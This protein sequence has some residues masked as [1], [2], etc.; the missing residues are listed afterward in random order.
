MGEKVGAGP[1]PLEDAVRAL[2]SVI[3]EVEQLSSEKGGPAG[4]LERVLVRERGRVTQLGRKVI[5]LAGIEDLSDAEMQTFGRLALAQFLV[6]RKKFA[7]LRQAL[8]AALEGGLR[9]DAKRA[10]RENIVKFI[11]ALGLHMKE[12]DALLQRRLEMEIAQLE[13][14]RGSIDR[15]SPEAE[16]WDVELDSLKARLEQFLA[17][18]GPC[19]QNE[20]P[21]RGPTGRTQISPQVSLQLGELSKLGCLCNHIRGKRPSRKLVARET[22][23]SIL[24]SGAIEYREVFPRL[25]HLAPSS[26]SAPESRPTMAACLPDECAASESVDKCEEYVVRM[27]S[28][29]GHGHKRKKRRGQAGAMGKEVRKLVRGLWKHRREKGVL[30][31]KKLRALADRISSKGRRPLISSAFEQR[32][33]G[34]F[35]RSMVRLVYVL[36]ADHANWSLYLANERTKGRL[37]EALVLMSKKHAEKARKRLG[38]GA[39]GKADYFAIC[40]QVTG[41]L[42][43]G[44]GPMQKY[45]DKEHK[46]RKREILSRVDRAAA[47]ACRCFAAQKQFPSADMEVIK[48]NAGSL[49]LEES[50]A[51]APFFRN[52]IM[53]VLRMFMIRYLSEVSRGSRASVLEFAETQFNYARWGLSHIEGEMKALVRASLPLL[54]FVSS[55]LF[56]NSPR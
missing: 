42:S 43:P 14:L 37:V 1:T 50:R 56:F 5:E 18:V 39:C 35:L 12:E 28:L 34:P 27:L 17:L 55:V 16:I 51:A 8:L 48:K 44:S 19:R 13:A 22:L 36:L 52:R 47:A 4:Q 6:D 41:G 3:S 9:E 15:N 38:V 11:R 45:F 29:M 7:F 24:E 53:G 54:I 32:E 46:Q 10:L 21:Q 30:H 40:R 49:G 23:L 25:C 20:G 26:G 33:Y 31:R 2:L